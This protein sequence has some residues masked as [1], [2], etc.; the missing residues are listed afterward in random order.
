MAAKVTG[1][2]LGVIVCLI[3]SAFHGRFRQYISKTA[4]QGIKKG[5]GDICDV[6]SRCVAQGNYFITPSQPPPFFKNGGGVSDFIA[7]T[8]QLL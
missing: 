7:A 4:I 6:P 1:I 2:Q 5:S 8:N 3:V